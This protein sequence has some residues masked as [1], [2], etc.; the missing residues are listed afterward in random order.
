MQWGISRSDGDFNVAPSDEDNHRTRSWAKDA[1]QQLASRAAFP[2]LPRQEW[3]DAIGDVRLDAPMSACGLRVNRRHGDVGLRTL[4]SE[5]RFIRYTRLLR[6]RHDDRAP[7]APL[8]ARPAASARIRFVGVAATMVG[9]GL[10]WAVAA[11]LCL[12]Q[13]YADFETIHAS[14]MTAAPITRR[15]YVA[16]RANELCGTI[17]RIRR[18][19]GT[20]ARCSSR[21]TRADCAGS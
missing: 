18:P 21:P 20:P 3:V 2:R 15:L 10:G 4:G 11:P 7:P 19:P 1:L 6:H 17:E 12:L 13:G 14:P 16:T 8:S 5:L 9:A